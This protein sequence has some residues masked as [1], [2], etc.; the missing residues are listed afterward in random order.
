MLKFLLAMLAVPPS[1]TASFTA[2]PLVLRA[3]TQSP[4]QVSS[5]ASILDPDEAWKKKQ[6]RKIEK[7]FQGMI[8]DAKNLLES[9]I[10]TLTL[11]KGSPRWEAQKQVY[12]KEYQA[13]AARIRRVA[14]EEFDRMVAERIFEKKQSKS[15]FKAGS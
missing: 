7:A 15:P 6:M 13:E 3:R 9:N 11:K 8:K 10:L 14:G 4:T 2:P 12:V 1:S 5:R